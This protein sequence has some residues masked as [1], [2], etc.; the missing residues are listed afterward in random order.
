MDLREVVTAGVE[1][2]FSVAA[3]F[4]VTGTYYARGS[5]PVYDPD[6]DTITFTPLT[7]NNVR[8]I[9][10]SISREER[11]ATAVTIS[12]VKILIPSTDLPGH[13]PQET[14]EMEY[15]GVRYNVLTIKSVPGDSLFILMARKK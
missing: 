15:G 11:E 5:D 4:V 13:Y 2:A 1:T 14:D 10:T 9:R 8:M 6:A 7:F 3:D 12:D